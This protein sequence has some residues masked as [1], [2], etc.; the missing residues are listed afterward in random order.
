MSTASAQWE[1]GRCCAIDRTETVED[2]LKAVFALTAAGSPASTSAIA[3]HLGVT[4]SSASTMVTRLRRAGLAKQVAWG[5]VH[6]SSHGMAHARSVVRRH[7]LVETFLHRQLGLGWDEIHREAEVLEH[8]LSER[9]TDLIDELLGHPDRDPHGDPIPAKDGP[10]DEHADEPLRAAPAGCSFV[11]GRVSDR[12]SG[13]LR[14]LAELGV[15][16]GA[17]FRVESSIHPRHGLTVHADGATTVLDRDLVDAVRGTV[18]AHGMHA[19]E[20]ER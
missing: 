2:Y 15:R 19:G 3:D 10:H 18:V 12:D 1:G 6:L 8:G 14:R 7:R 16:P 13:I 11:V 5:Q 9:V 4:P 17:T 20:V